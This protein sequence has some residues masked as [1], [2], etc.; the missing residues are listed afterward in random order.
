MREGYYPESV[1][2]QAALPRFR[3]SLR[4]FPTRC[5]Y[6]ADS[7][8][9][10]EDKKS[11]R[12]PASGAAINRRHNSNGT[13]ICP[14]VSWSVR[15]ITRNEVRPPACSTHLVQILR[16]SP[17][18]SVAENDP[19]RSTGTGRAGVRID[20]PERSAGAV[21]QPFAVARLGTRSRL[22]QHARGEKHKD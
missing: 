1:T 13:I 20:A 7:P 15:C 17:R 8:Q 5:R 14:G 12:R 22:C 16:E 2:H 3:P 19:A 18:R 4:G 10:A 9:N 6:R 11:R 21:R